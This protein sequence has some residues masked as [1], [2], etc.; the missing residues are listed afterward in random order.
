MIP[1]RFPSCGLHFNWYHVYVTKFPLPPIWILIWSLSHLRHPNF[2]WALGSK[3]ILSITRVT[4]LVLNDLQ[5]VIIPLWQEN[6]N[7]N[8]CDLIWNFLYFAARSNIKRMTLAQWR[9]WHWSGQLATP[10]TIPPTPTV[11]HPPKEKWENFWW[12]KTHIDVC[13]IWVG[14]KFTTF[15]ECEQPTGVLNVSSSKNYSNMTDQIFA[16]AHHA[17]LWHIL[18][19]FLDILIFF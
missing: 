6:L 10:L 19:R 11:K 18:F 4:I 9:D 2:L 12:F 1:Q 16:M 7:A 13:P 8:I 14:R 5:L 3:K 17:T 15:P